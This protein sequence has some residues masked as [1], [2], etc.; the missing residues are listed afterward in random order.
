MNHPA[1][2]PSQKRLDAIRNR[3]SLASPVWGVAADG[4]MTVTAGADEAAAQPVAVIVQGAAFGDAEL[5]CH[6]VDDIT[7]LLDRYTTLATR[8]RDATRE[9]EKSRPKPA[10]FAAECAMKCADAAFKKYLEERHGLERPLTDERVATRIRTVLN[11]KSRAELNRDPA[12]TERW[13]SLRADFEQ[14][15][16]GVSFQKAHEEQ[17]HDQAVR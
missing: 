15:R 11:I 6:V 3:I 4:E 8:Y 10:D 5:L 2:S 17:W 1:V 13:K 7:W 9:L 16:R 14:W 12:A